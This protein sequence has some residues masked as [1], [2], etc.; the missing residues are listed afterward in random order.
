MITY[1]KQLFAVNMVLNLFKGWFPLS[2]NFC[3]DSRNF[4][5]WTR[6]SF[7]RVNKIEAMYERTLVNVKL[8][9]GS[10]FTFTRDLYFIYARK[11]YVR[12]CGK[13]TFANKREG[14]YER[15]CVKVKVDHLACIIYVRLFPLSC[16]WFPLSRNF[17]VRTH[18][19]FACVN[20]IEVMYARS[21]VIVKVEWGSTFTF[22]RDLPYI[23]SILLTR[24]KLT[25]VHT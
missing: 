19:K 5:V 10:T 2:R 21:R 3:V 4:Y 23:V 1:G 13:F 9:R 14:M 12:T 6:V 18:V 17:Y 8:E 25:W 16:N 24:V 15:S 22:M 7:T 11:T 20:E